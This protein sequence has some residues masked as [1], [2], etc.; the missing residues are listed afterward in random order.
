MSLGQE[1]VDPVEVS[2]KILHNPLII[3]IHQV[4]KLVKVSNF[5]LFVL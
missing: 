2:G 5:C 4:F 1:N 3:I